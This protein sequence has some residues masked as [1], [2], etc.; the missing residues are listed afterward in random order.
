MVLTSCCIDRIH[1]GS[2]FVLYE[3]GTVLIS[4]FMDGIQNGYEFV[5]W[6]E[7]RTVLV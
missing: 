4:C 6:L 1:N 5:D 2:D 7:P 3:F